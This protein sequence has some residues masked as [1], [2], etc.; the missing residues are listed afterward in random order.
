MPYESD[1]ERWIRE[2]RAAGKADGL[3]AAAAE[4]ANAQHDGH[5]D[6]HIGLEDCCQI[7]VEDLERAILAFI[8][9]PSEP[10][11]ADE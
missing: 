7:V 1:I 11:G 5:T 10:G 2:A 9:S 8:P 3:R 4:L 6:G